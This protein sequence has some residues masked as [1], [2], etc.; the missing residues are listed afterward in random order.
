MTLLSVAVSGQKG[1][2][3]VSKCFMG[4]IW[5]LCNQDKPMI[6]LL[7]RSAPKK[8]FAI[9]K[10]QRKRSKRPSKNAAIIERV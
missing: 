10:C 7:L 5:T 4:L 9:A 2:A 3:G 1:R 8:D 6:A